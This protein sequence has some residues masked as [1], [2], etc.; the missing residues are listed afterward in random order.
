MGKINRL[1]SDAINQIAAGEVIERPAAALKEIVENA[2]DASS[3]SINIWCEDGG[4][5][6]ILVEDDGIGISK[7]DLPVAILR[8]ATSK[9]KPDENGA[10]D[11]TNI[12]SLGFRGEALPSI[13]AVARLKITSKTDNDNNA[14][15]IEV[16]GG[17][18]SE[19]RPAPWASLN[20]GT[21]IEIREITAL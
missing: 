7:D 5:S 12:I 11:L 16:N 14:W 17:Q 2:L 4:L 19:I 20:S 6:R 10:I 15:E 9:L 3:K 13:G 21:R 1:S 18:I 8:H